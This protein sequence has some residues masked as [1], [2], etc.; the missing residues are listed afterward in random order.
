MVTPGLVYTEISILDA[1]ANIRLTKFQEI[2]IQI[3]ST[4]NPTT[5]VHSMKGPLALGGQR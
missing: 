1:S 3:T 2:D 5:L 4:V